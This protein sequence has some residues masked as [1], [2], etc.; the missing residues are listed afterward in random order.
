MTDFEQFPWILHKIKGIS[1]QRPFY[2][3]MSMKYAKKPLSALGSSI[4]GGRYNHIG[5]FEILYVAPDPQTSVEE[6]ITNPS[7]LFPPKVMIT[8]EVDLQ[9]VLD[10]SDPEILASLDVDNMKLSLPWR[11][12][13]DIDQIEAYT[14]T[15]GRL[16]YE[17]NILEGLLYPSAKVPGRYNLAIFPDLLLPGSSVKVYDPEGVLQETI[18]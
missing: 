6:T 15:I 14:Q 3:F 11:K 5:T 1:L 13:Q 2:R 12:K 9:R 16:V 7:F 18:E 8:I 4:S 17:S 10:F